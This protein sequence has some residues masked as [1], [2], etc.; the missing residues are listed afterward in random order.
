MFKLVR[1]QACAALVAVLCGL[2]FFGL[3]GAIW[4]GLGGLVC[5]LPS[6]L[7]A[8]YLT[9]VTQRHGR[10]QVM[11]FFVGE[12]V[13]TVLSIGIL[14]SVGLLFSGAHWGAVVMGLIITLQAN[15]FAFLVKL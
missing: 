13:K 6:L 3:R 15:F 11:A 1:L 7:F 9:Y 10:A 8:C 5:V 4:A 14:V 2:L 12:A